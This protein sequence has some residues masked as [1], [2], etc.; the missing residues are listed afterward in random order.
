MKPS[1]TRELDK[2]FSH[3]KIRLSRFQLPTE[4]VSI[5]D[6]W[7]LVFLAQNLASS[8]PMVIIGCHSL[9]I[10]LTIATLI[11]LPVLFEGLLQQKKFTPVHYI[12][13]SRRIQI[14]STLSIPVQDPRN[15]TKERS[16]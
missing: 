1:S 11:C 13:F 14:T 10:F 8:H 7:T 15:S 12:P 4:I 16:L 9:G 5:N 3:V 6:V 2:L